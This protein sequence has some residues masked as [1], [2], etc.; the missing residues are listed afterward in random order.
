MVLVDSNVWIS[1]NQ[2]N[3]DLMA[4]VA[5]EALLDEGEAALCGP[6]Q[7]EVLGAI[8]RAHRDRFDAYFSLVPFLSTTDSIW[9]QAVALARRV[10]DSARMTLPWND[11]LI[12]AIA[13]RYDCRVY[14]L[15]GHFSVLAAHGGLRRYAPGPGGTYTPEKRDE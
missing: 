3:G 4:R 5:L 11:H 15:D 2:P 1:A 14:S 6:V 7:L 13:L 10:F 9:R 12:A 8:R